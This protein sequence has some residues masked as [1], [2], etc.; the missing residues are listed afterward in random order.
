MVE[1]FWLLRGE[2]MLARHTDRVD[3]YG[4]EVNPNVRSN[5]EAALRMDLKRVALIHREQL[6]LYQKF[7][8][9][10][11][12][13]DLLICPGVTVLPFP[14]DQD[15]PAPG[16]PRPQPCDG[17]G[18]R[19]ASRPVSVYIEAFPRG[20]RGVRRQIEAAMRKGADDMI[21]WKRAVL[22]GIAATIVFDVIGLL[23]TRQWNVPMMLAAKLEVGL[24]GGVVAHY[25]NGIILGIIF[26]GVGPSLWGPSWVRGLTY[27]LIQDVFGVWLFLNPLLGMG[28]A[29]LKAGAM[30]PVVSLIKHLSFGLVLALLYPVST[31]S[32][33]G[34]YE[35]SAADRGV[36]AGGA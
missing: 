17:R 4:P 31:P 16:P 25:G 32:P 10:F 29:G 2:Y 9:F 27:M 30:T 36:R 26:A 24:A 22:S 34:R 1:T 13:I 28:I 33:E 6:R 18:R 21:N 7:Q 14:F 11:D 35:G 20:W 8:D 23:L 12:E 3:R 15:R 19:L 5:Y